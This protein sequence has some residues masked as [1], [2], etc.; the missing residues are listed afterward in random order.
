MATTG[1]DYYEI[2]GVSRVRDRGRDQAGVPR[3]SRASSTRTSPNEPDAEERFRE[4]VEAYEVL[5][6][7]RDARALRPFRP[8]RSAERRLPPDRVRLRQPRRH[9]LGLL[10]RG[11]LRRRGAPAPRSRR[12]RRRRGRDRARGGRNAESSAKSRSRSRGP[13][14]SA[15][16]AAA[17]SLAPRRST[18][19]ECGGS[20]RLQQVSRTRLRRVHPQPALCA[21]RRRRAHRRASRASAAREPVACSRSE[22]RGRDP[23]RDPRRP[24]HPDL[25]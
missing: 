22:P 5:S 4:A 19:D 21:L 23:G 9:L 8:C 18:C 20:G 3:G 12:R 1:R 6:K 16:A 25:R 17:S 10:R 7:T 13:A 15:A 24:A 11:R 2:L 14:T